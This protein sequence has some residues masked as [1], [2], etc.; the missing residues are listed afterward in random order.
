MKT[1]K[2]IIISIVLLMLCV[3]GIVGAVKIKNI[4]DEKR[5]QEILEEERQA[6]MYQM[7]RYTARSMFTTKE[8]ISA[9]FL[10]LEDYTDIVFVHTEEEGEDY[11][12]DILVAWPGETSKERLY[13]L[14]QF[15][16]EQEVDLESYS[17]QYPITM[18]D[19]VDKWE[20]VH[21]VFSRLSSASH[22]MINM[23]GWLLW[24]YGRNQESDNV[25]EKIYYINRFDLSCTIDFLIYEGDFY[26]DC[27]FVMSKEE[28]QGY[29]DNIIVAWPNR[30][31]D[32]IIERLNEYV[33]ENEIDLELYSLQ[34]PVTRE[35]IVE[36]WE[37][38][39]ALLDSF[40][41]SVRSWILS[42]VVV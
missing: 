10:E 9:T 24:Y 36:K 5:H 30:W 3:A 1:K 11:G 41:S 14:N 2:R 15:V 23:G 28:A 29:A 33:Y 37:E 26:I 22:E 16:I 18:N 7:H 25:R 20:M 39:N 12:E 13:L 38:L 40:T 34:Y 8:G 21:K 4:N 19:L 35:D 17:L 31:T 32:R 6:R 27:V 42:G